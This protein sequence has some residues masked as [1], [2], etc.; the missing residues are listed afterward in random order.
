M[1]DKYT[2]HLTLLGEEKTVIDSRKMG[3]VIISYFAH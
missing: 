2:G 3:F 1:P